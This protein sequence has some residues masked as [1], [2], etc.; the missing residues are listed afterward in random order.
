MHLPEKQAAFRWGY[1]AMVG[2]MVGRFA[3]TFLMR[4]I[5][6]QDLLWLYAL[7]NILLLTLGITTRG[8]IALYAVM[9]VPF[10]MSIM[11]PTIFALGI[12]GLG[13]SAKKASS[14]IVMAIMGGAILPKVMGAVADRY[15]LSRGFIVPTLCFG[16]VAFYGFMWPRLSKAEG[17]VTV[18]TSGGH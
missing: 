13:Q 16:F 8:D 11:F 15:D 2:F 5:K 3:G 7:I 4:F 10:F 17:A 18:S 1:I 6:P 9:A 14:F 12:F